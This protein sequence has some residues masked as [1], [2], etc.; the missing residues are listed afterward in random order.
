MVVVRMFGLCGEEVRLWEDYV[1][2]L[3]ARLGAEDVLTIHNARQIL[4]F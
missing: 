4:S 3:Y 1:P 2:F